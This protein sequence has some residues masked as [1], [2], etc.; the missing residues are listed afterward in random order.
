[1]S[2]RSSTQSWLA[3]GAGDGE[4]L[5][6][7]REEAAGVSASSCWSLLSFMS[8]TSAHFAPISIS[9]LRAFANSWSPLAVT[10]SVLQPSCSA[11]DDDSGA[12]NSLNSSGEELGGRLLSEAGVRLVDVLVLGWEGS[13]VRTTTLRLL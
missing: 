13:A 7:T 4:G 10:G 6:L 12:V 5:A 8:Y 9:S 2:K 11:G 1:M 3:A